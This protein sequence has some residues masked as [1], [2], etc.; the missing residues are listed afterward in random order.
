MNLRNQPN[1]AWLS[2]NDRPARV[3]AVAC[4]H[5]GRLRVAFTL[6]ELLLTVSLLLLLLG[7]M[8]FSF[9]RLRQGVDLDEGATQLE[10]LL[11][12]ARA[13]AAATGR[14]VQISFEEQIDE[15]LSAPLGNLQVWWEP[16][17]LARPGVFEP[18]R[19]AEPYVR[20]ITELVS[21]E[22][23][24]SLESGRLSAGRSQQPVATATTVRNVE[25]EGQGL[26]TAGTGDFEPLTFYPDGSGDS[27]ELVL[28]SRDREDDRLVG[29]QFVGV[30][31]TLRRR[32]I[33]RE[34][35][36]GAAERPA[37]PGPLPR[38]APTTAGTSVRGG[39]T[40]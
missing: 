5:R 26:E 4:E 40:R 7:A 31:G 24:R 21:I 17:P 15:G 3:R 39:K 29:V 12:F 27:A 8:V 14:Q 23:V 16:D 32:F 22:E 20:G 11:R 35:L 34:G 13:H 37:E 36:P 2:L 25:T 28:A 1:K 30:T 10:A 9:S 38:P 6:V 18:L 33:P 19:E